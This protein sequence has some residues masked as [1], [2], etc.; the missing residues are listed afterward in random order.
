MIYIRACFTN[1]LAVNTNIS[2]SCKIHSEVGK[3]FLSLCLLGEN[4][5]IPFST[6]LELRHNHNVVLYGPVVLAAPGLVL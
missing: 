1:S 5:E 3:T 6:S 2:V 4:M